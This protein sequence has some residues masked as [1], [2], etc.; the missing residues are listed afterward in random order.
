MSFAE[1]GVWSMGAGGCMFFFVGVGRRIC[2]MPSVW[3]VV[4][5]GRWSE[6]VPMLTVS[7]VVYWGGGGH[8]VRMSS[9]LLDEVCVLLNQVCFLVEGS[10]G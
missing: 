7:V 9:I 10:V 2:G 3:R 8:E 6:S 4:R 1:I 5:S